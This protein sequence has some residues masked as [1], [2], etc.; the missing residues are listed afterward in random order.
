MA[1]VSKELLR[2]IAEALARV[3]VDP[4]DLPGIE[5]QLDAQL[6]G[7]AKLDDLDLLTVEPATVILPPR[8]RTRRRLT[9][10]GIAEAGERLRRRTLSPWS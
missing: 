6:D 8:R 9:L 10:L 4:S 2:T 3:P 7:L 5:A 1:S